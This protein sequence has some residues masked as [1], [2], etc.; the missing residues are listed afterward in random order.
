[1]A[2]DGAGALF[3]LGVRLTKLDSTGAPLVGA[4][5][6]YTTNS[7]VRIGFGQ[8]YS[9]PDA[10]E[11]KN[12]AGLTC[13]YY[14]PSAVLLGGTIEEFRFCTPDPYVL[15]FLVGGDVITAGG[16]N[17]AQTVT[18]T[19]TPTG[20]SFTLTYDGQ[21]T[22][23][24]AY[25]ASAAAVKTAL[26]ALSN[27]SASDVTTTG[28]P[29]PGSPIVVTFTGGLAGENVVQMTATASLTGGTSPAVTVTTTTPGVEG[30]TATGYRAPEV[31]TDPLPYGVAIEAWSNAILDNAV[32]ASLPY[33]HWVIG[34]AKLHPSEAL[35]LGGEDPTQPVFEGTTEQNANFGDGP[36]GDIGFP[37]SRIYQYNRV[38]AIPD[39][40]A[41]LVAVV[42]DA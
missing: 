3:A 11:L 2:Y 28:G 20:G 25:N 9:E 8:T 5:N 36:V 14:A 18:V 42:A 4:G 37:T 27:V 29:L 30:A 16:T 6:S 7:L 10:I 34:R 23:A 26:V 31:N 24:I 39:L 32:A 15:Q 17:E 19:G 40:S 1:M 22:G 13:V 33:Q 21:T 12:G 38:N 41:G 35:A